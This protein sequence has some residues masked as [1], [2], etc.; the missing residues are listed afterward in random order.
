MVAIGTLAVGIGLNTVIFSIVNG[1]L[2][3]P[4][5]YPDPDRLLTVLQTNPDWIESSNPS[6]RGMW[7][8][9]PVSYPVYLDWR[10]MSTSFEDLG[11][12]VPSTFAMEGGDHPELLNGVEITSGVLGALGVAPAFGRSFR[13]EDDEVGSERL[14]ILSHG[15]WQRRFGGDRS[16]LGQVIFLNDELYTVTGVMPSGFYFPTPQTELWS[17]LDDRRRNGGRWRQFGKVIA[18][19]KPEISSIAS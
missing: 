8:R 1:V 4:L 11:I 7:D 13:P 10:Q 5:P 14:A 18:R 17:T 9:F 2:L 3:R 6:L 16:I 12:Y 19:L 15:L